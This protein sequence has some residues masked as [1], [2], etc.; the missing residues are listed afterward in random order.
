[1]IHRGFFVR[2]CLKSGEVGLFYDGMGGEK[3]PRWLGFIKRKVVRVYKKLRKF[4]DKRKN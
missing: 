1:M 3:E 2:L 4:S